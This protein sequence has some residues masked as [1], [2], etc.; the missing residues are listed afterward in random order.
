MNQCDGYYTGSAVPQPTFQSY[1]GIASDGGSYGLVGGNLI[2]AI[3][4]DSFQSVNVP[5]APWS[6]EIWLWIA[7]YSDT[8]STTAV[9]GFGAASE[10][11][12]M[13]FNS[14]GFPVVT[15]QGAFATA[16]LAPGTGWKHFGFT[17]S[18][19]T[20]GV[21]VNGVSVSSGA[22]T[23]PSAP[24]MGM[25]VGP[26]QATGTPLYVCEA[27]AYPRLL[28]ATDFA[29]HHNAA[30]QLVKPRW[31]AQLNGTC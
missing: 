18:S 22:H 17:V 6:F 4:T 3:G 31:R 12:A 11:V 21:F 25:Q 1:S 9:C 16:Y 26:G 2:R 5:T 27:A 8:T 10:L 29:R 7:G 23:F 14:S 20:V 19:T 28:T 30:D 15:G 13:S 24:R